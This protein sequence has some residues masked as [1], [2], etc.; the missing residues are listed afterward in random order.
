MINIYVTSNYK[1][2]K[3]ILAL[4]W[5]YVSVCGNGATHVHELQDDT[6]TCPPGTQQYD[7]YCCPPGQWEVL[8]DIKCTFMGVGGHNCSLI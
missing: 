8:T 6:D 7:K 2:Y 4:Q 5:C 3:V 1:A